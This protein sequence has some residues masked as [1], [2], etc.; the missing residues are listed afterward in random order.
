MR[1]AI[2]GGGVAGL[3]AAWQL[4]RLAPEAAASG[5]PLQV[6]LFESSNRLGG[7]VHTVREGGFII[8]TGPDAWLTAKP[9]ASD[10]AQELGLREDL[11]PSNDASRKTWIYLRTPDH[12]A[13]RL[14]PMPDRMTLMV[15]SDL[16]A[17]DHS[18]LFSPAAVAAYRAEPTRA[19]EL[20]AS[21][22]AAD[23]SVASFT[24]RHFGPEVLQRIAAPL[25][26]GVFGGDVNTLSA[27]AALPVLVQM[28]RTHGSLV[29]AL[30]QQQ[31][32]RTS[33]SPDGQPPPAAPALFTSLRTGVAALTDRLTAQIP[34]AWLHLNTT[35]LSLTPTDLTWTI[36]HSTAGRRTTETFDR[37]MIALSSDAARALLAPLDPT[38]ASLLPSQSSSAVLVAFAFPDATRVLTPPGFGLL[39]PP[40]PQRRFNFRKDEDAS[41]A[42]PLP[43]HPVSTVPAPEP[44]HVIPLASEYQTPTLL[45]ACTFADQKFA[46]RVPPGG[47]LLRAFFGGAAATRLSACNNDEIAAIARLELARI[48]H[49]YTYAAAPLTGP[50]PRPLPD[51]LI[52]V[53]RRLPASLPQYAV[54][55]LDRIVEFQSRLSTQLPGLVLLGN[56]LHGLGIPDVI[57]DARQAARHLVHHA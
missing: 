49:T 28:E 42:L 22:P 13:P 7:I 32:T 52:T 20:L 53:V 50:T 9:W 30:I 38:T 55:H 34:P 19:T 21:I 5:S 1:I 3:T 39:V 17:L 10:L 18:P 43:Q 25:L 48:L 11:I 51:P 41:P 56:P 54:G 27:R 15:P 37:V 29:A 8:E 4:A 35:V 14:V 36:T 6:S 44:A 46:H 33:T 16:D 12:P 24:L 45:Q 40:S 31:A 57:R 2:I 26:S 47:R 23:E